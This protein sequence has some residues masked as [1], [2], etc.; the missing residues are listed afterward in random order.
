MLSGTKGTKCS[1]NYTVFGKLRDTGYYY[2][3]AMF[4]DCPKTS[5]KNSDDDDDND[6]DGGGDND[7]M[8]TIV[9]FPDFRKYGS[10]LLG[11][12]SAQ[13]LPYIIS[14]Y[15][16]GELATLSRKAGGKS[17][18]PGDESVNDCW[19][20]GPASSLGTVWLS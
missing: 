20:P 7:N 4:S 19:S 8:T 16:H 14:F 17:R 5:Y 9:L 3:A 11:R 15:P 12:L 18:P 6:A 1:I 10:L 2:S 13:C